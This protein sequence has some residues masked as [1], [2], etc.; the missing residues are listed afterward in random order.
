MEGGAKG[1]ADI[2]EYTIRTVLK[3]LSRP[4]IY[5]LLVS[6]GAEKDKVV[7][8]DLYDLPEIQYNIKHLASF[9]GVITTE[10]ANENDQVRINVIINSS[11]YSILFY[12]DAA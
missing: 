8:E 5:Q 9:A 11:H 1:T 12:F 4:L 6:K 10:D 3:S 7:L 2:R